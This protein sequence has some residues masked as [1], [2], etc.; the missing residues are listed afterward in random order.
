M[1][2]VTIDGIEYRYFDHLYAVSRCGRVIR[3]HLPYTPTNHPNG[4]LV[5]GRRRL[6]HRVVAYCWLDSFDSKKHVHHINGDKKDNRVENLE[7]L[8]QTEHLNERHAEQ[9]NKN[10]KYVRTPETIEKIRQSRLGR[11]TSEE[12]KAKQRAAL[13]GRKRP[14]FHRAPHS[15][16]SR[17]NRSLNHVR[18][19][20][21]LVFGHKY[22]SFSEAARATGINKM[23]ARKRCLSDNSPD[24]KDMTV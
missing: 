24:F 14:F 2:S 20:R 13:L 17:E 11:V 23:T 12:T 7:C 8:S 21:C 19:T 15:Q 3:N 10:G 5:L 6:M 9:M 22:R 18:N 4:Y 16:E 1:L